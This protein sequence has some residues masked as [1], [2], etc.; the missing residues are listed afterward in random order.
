MK[1]VK[2]GGRYV[3]QST[4]EE[5]E[6]PKAAGFR[7]DREARRWWTADAAVAARLARYADPEIRTELEA[8]GAAQ[9]AALE[10]SRA[11]DA[12][13]D[14]P[15]P[16]GLAYMPFQ[17]AGVAYMTSRP[18]ALNGDDP[19]L[20]KT[21]QAAGTINADESVRRVL[22]IC[23]ATLRENWRRE[24]TRWLVRPLTI[25]IA[26]TTAWPETDVVIL[27]YDIASKLRAR[28]RAETWDLVVLDEAHYCKS[29]DAQ[30]TAAV[31][32]REARRATAS[33]PAVAA[34]PGVA[35]RRRL[36]LTGTPIVN[37]PSEAFPV[38]HWLDP[39][40]W[41]RF[42]PYAMRYCG[43]VNTGYGWDVTGA[44]HL[45][46]LQEKLRSTLMV[47][48]LKS[49]VLAELPAKRRQVI[50]LPTNG[51]KAV[52]QAEAR[53]WAEREAAIAEAR[54]AV[55]LAKAG[56]SDEAYAEAVARL[57][58]ATLA[59]FTEMSALRHETA[60][61]KVPYVAEHVRSLLD[62]GV[63]V[64]LFAHHHDVIAR[65]AAELKEYGPVTLT[66]ETPMAQR[67]GLVDR[68][69]TDAACR[70]F[71]GSITAAGV[72]LTLTA[73]SN[74]VFAELDWVPGNMTQ[75][76]DRT[77]RIG[78]REAVL[79]QHL[80]LDGSLD[81]RIA[82]TLVAKQA[83]IDG[84]LDRVTERAE[85]A[86]PD[87]CAT[88]TVRRSRVAELAE[89]MTDERRAVVHRAL[90]LVAGMCDGAHAQDGHGFNKIDA[91]VGRELA[92][93]ATLTGRQAA[94]GYLVVRKYRRQLGADVAAEL[95]A[96]A[97]EAEGVAA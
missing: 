79:V 31:V 33:K 5:R 43:A 3:A 41:P 47:R 83:V 29:P 18:A 57:T 58:E 23:P 6:A 78:Q 96:F 19:G 8:A 13:V 66:G 38:L 87:A 74:V 70:V 35:G 81:A 27:N 20:G 68:F 88:E 44:S 15:C 72:G 90:R 56:D 86:L 48:R 53:A 55:E 54:A 46:E 34:D 1:I 40:A 80:V 97:I 36:A 37:R 82:H 17:K 84:A 73:S 61:A 94:L 45:D 30:R 11:A 85:I 64:V 95:E 63:K 4:Y 77:H 92:L 26:S 51:A 91:R 12:D 69:Q 7:W 16:E 42:W 76:E 65:L 32:G 22:V 62:G 89:R 21:I 25:G 14:V 28:L 24:L 10:A 49:E 60:L 71:I 67:Q 9:Q 50:V 52:V 93:Q 59:S 39:V 75:A 2:D